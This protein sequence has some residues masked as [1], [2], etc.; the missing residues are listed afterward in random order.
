MCK[1][2]AG[3]FIV[4]SVSYSQYVGS[5]ACGNCHPDKLASQSKTGHA[6]AL[7]KAAPGSRGEWEFGAG[8]K[9]K[10]WVSQVDPEIYA[11]HGLSFFTA[12]K[13][14]G[15]TPGHTDANNALYRTFDPEAT[16]LKCFRCHSTGPLKVE[17]SGAIEPSE[18]GV[19]CE[20]CHG[21][22]A[23]HVASSGK[24]GTILNPKRLSPVALN[25]FCGVCHRKSPE[26]DWTDKWKTRHQP[27]YL[28]QSACFRK[29]G[30]LTCVTCHDPHTPLSEVASQ[31]DQRCA[32][33]HKAVSHRTPATSRSCI[34]C[35]MPQVAV[36]PQ[37][38]FTNHW[39][40]IYAKDSYLVPARTVAHGV[41]PLAP[42]DL[43]VV[44]PAD[45]STLKPLFEQELANKEKQFGAN[46]PKVARS[47]V[48][49][50]RFN[51]D[52]G[53][54]AAAEP[55]LVRA[56]AID[57][58]P[59]DN[60][61]LGQLLSALGRNQEAFAHFQSAAKAS[62]PKIAAE[63]F[64]SL[65][66]LDPPH[67]DEYYR[68]AI[69]NAAKDPK[70]LAI[71]LNDLAMTLQEKHDYQNAESL[72]RRALAIQRKEFGSDSPA[73]GATLTNLGSLFETVG[74]HSEAEQMEREAIRIFER[75]LGPWS[76]E[77]A[78]S[79][80]NLADVLATKGDLSQAAALYRRAISIDETVYGA[81]NPEVAGDL[82]NLGTLLK[83][84]G[85]ASAG[86]ST[87]QRA[88]DIYEKAFGAA[89]PQAVQ[90][91]TILH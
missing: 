78:I 21:P 60:Q 63:S 70:H 19:H 52:N 91:R 33:C 36:N 45:P 16:T 61:T 59:A 47:L 82:V 31:Y 3:L 80:T 85:D 34:S 58:T 81:D 26:S 9:A 38:S 71:L 10:T 32:A 65:A 17:A 79:C 90:I 56:L 50:A 25:D 11:E 39:I 13:S 68:S 87:L 51:I 73:A 42:A 23:E 57:E 83:Q 75:K 5:S 30:T 67:A 7:S 76:A 4:C 28:S 40:G 43:K 27:S 35:H 74:H 48:D 84:S 20:S 49:L 22:G 86:N 37:V 29:S 53:D 6:H 18:P 1:A 62:D 46:D 66:L 69:D 41:S 54:P 77:L 8:E 15:L 72:F 14:M 89:S 24:A 44:A 2:F 64:A 88:L 12:T 55:L